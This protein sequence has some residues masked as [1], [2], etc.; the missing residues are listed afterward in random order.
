MAAHLSVI[1]ETVGLPIVGSADHLHQCI[2]GKR[3]ERD[4]PNVV[5]IV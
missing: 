4:D 1:A 3:T 2:E 5:V